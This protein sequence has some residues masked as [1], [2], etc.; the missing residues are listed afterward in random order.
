[1]T[2]PPQVYLVL[3]PEGNLFGVLYDLARSRE[4]AK[5]IAGAII[6]VPILEDYR[7]AN[8]APLPEGEQP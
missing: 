3:M 4:V 1:M 7:N 5:A 2:E 6:A 8:D